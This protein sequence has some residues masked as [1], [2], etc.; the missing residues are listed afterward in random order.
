MGEREPY[1]L[2]V[3]PGK[4]T[5]WAVWDKDGNFIKMGTTHSDND[6]RTLLKPSPQS[7]S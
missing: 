7:K 1:Y 5:G 4:H 2:A 3:D 6:L